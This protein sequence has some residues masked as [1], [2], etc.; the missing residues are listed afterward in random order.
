MAEHHELI[1]QAQE[2]YN[3]KQWDS[4]TVVMQQIISAQPD[5]AIHRYNL[6]VAL[7]QLERYAECE[8]SLK[9]CLRLNPDDRNAR[10]LLSRLQENVAA[11]STAAFEV[12]PTIQESAAPTTVESALANPRNDFSPISSNTAQVSPPQPTVQNSPTTVAGSPE[13]SSLFGPVTEKMFREST[14]VVTNI[15]L[16]VLA[17]IVGRVILG[18]LPGVDTMM[19]GLSLYEWLSIGVMIAVIVFIMR[20]YVPLHNMVLYY[21]S[22]KLKINSS[23][24]RYPQVQ[25]L[26]NHSQMLRSTSS[27]YTHLYFRRFVP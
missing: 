22:N 7:Y 24:R 6:S 13:S 23:D 12:T 16:T 27:R 25:K 15:A 4:L 14:P 26:C 19:G 20:G 2:L 9:A 11:Q 8:Q 1:K 17:L 3:A 21:F 10:G 5:A 18:L